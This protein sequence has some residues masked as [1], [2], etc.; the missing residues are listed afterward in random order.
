MTISDKAA[1]QRLT[2]KL[3]DKLTELRYLYVRTASA[4]VRKLIKREITKV[5][6]QLKELGQ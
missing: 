2:Y 5:E 4:L 1:V 3:Q 6:Q